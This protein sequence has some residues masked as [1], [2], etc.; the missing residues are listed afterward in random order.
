[1]YLF[2]LWQH[3]SL[4]EAFSI[5][6]CFCPQQSIVRTTTTI[7]VDPWTDVLSVIIQT[8]FGHC[9]CLRGSKELYEVRFFLHSLQNMQHFISK[10]S[11]SLF[12]LVVH[13]TVATFDSRVRSRPGCAQLSCACPDT[14]KLKKALLLSEFPW[15]S[16]YEVWCGY[17]WL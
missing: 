1:M 7:Y 5:E 15:V 10:L 9:P 8:C 2:G 6:G 16:V 17:L 12:C 11:Q 13:M 4:G 14:N 3:Y